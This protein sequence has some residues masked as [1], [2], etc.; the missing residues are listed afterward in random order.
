MLK[1]HERYFNAYCK[2]L[3]K[4][5]KKGEIKESTYLTQKSLIKR[6]LN[7]LE[8]EGVKDLVE[9]V[10]KVKLPYQHSKIRRFVEYF[11]PNS[12]SFDWKLNR[13]LQSLTEL[14]KEKVS[15]AESEK[16]SDFSFLKGKVVQVAFSDGERKKAEV[17]NID[18]ERNIVELLPITKNG[19]ASFILYVPLSSIKYFSISEELV[20]LGK[21]A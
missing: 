20:D 6:W 4:L 18:T 21:E 8:R 13:Y 15:T 14:S 11:F 9:G 2:H 1:E 5:L 19:S 16:V 17:V 12:S 10:E 3:E 7:L